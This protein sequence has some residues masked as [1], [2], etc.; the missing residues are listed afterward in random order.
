MQD[1]SPDAVSTEEQNIYLEGLWSEELNGRWEFELVSGY[2]AEFDSTVIDVEVFDAF[3]KALTVDQ[4][5]CIIDGRVIGED[6]RISG[7]RLCWSC[8]HAQTEV[9]A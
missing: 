6:I 3:T 9:D 7:N 8:F 5:R 2:A 4:E 1:L